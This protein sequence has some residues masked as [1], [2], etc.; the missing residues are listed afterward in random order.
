MTVDL[1]HLRAAAD[2]GWT[3]FVTNDMTPMVAMPRERFVE[4][5]QS[6]E[7][8]LAAP[9][10]VASGLNLWSTPDHVEW[11]VTVRGSGPLPDGWSPGEVALVPHSR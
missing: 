7:A 4:Y 2:D 3:E 8:V 11:S 10:G 1:T 5:R 9:V 6:A